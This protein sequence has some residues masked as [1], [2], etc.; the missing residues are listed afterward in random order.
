MPITLAGFVDK[1]K[2][3]DNILR[4]ENSK[5]DLKQ[6]VNNSVEDTLKEKFPAE[7]GGIIQQHANEIAVIKKGLFTEYLEKINFELRRLYI[8]KAE[9][10]N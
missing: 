8:L 9:I 1:K 6:I 3:S 2:L 7:Y 4:F 10:Y 5:R